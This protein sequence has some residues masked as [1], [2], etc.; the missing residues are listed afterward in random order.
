MNPEEVK[1]LAILSRIKVNSEEVGK[2][3]KQLGDILDYVQK[4]QN[5]KITAKKHQ[6]N[7]HIVKLR[8]DKVVFR[9][10]KENEE[11]ISQFSDRSANLLK[12]KKIL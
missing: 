12:V 11:I 6:V 2:F 5:Y 10:P 4:V 9:K 1:K 8:A 7:D 3:A